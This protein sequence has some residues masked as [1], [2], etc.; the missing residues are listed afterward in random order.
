MKA[1]FAIVSGE[2]DFLAESFGRNYVTYLSSCIGF[3]TIKQTFHS[4]HY[5]KRTV[6]EFLICLVFHICY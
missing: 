3:P 1:E 2:N 6:S 4:V 5:C